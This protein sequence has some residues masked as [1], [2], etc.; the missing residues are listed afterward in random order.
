MA[1]SDSPALSCRKNSSVLA[2]CMKLV[3]AGIY[4]FAITG[5]ALAGRH[6]WTIA[7]ISLPSALSPSDALIPAG[8]VQRQAS[9]AQRNFLVLLSSAAILAAL[10]CPALT[11]TQHQGFAAGL[12]D[13]S[14]CASF[15]F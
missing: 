12:A 1:S 3:L 5:M 7:G 6:P 13:T 15:C 14:G 4:N 11:G 2:C 9:N 10:F 8:A